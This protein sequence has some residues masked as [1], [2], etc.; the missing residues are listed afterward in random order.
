MIVMHP[1]E[2]LRLVTP[3][4]DLTEDAVC[5][6]IRIPAFRIEVQLRRKIVKDRPESLIGVSLVEAHRHIAGEVD[7]KTAVGFRPPCKNRLATLAI[8]FLH[9]SVPPDPLSA[10]FSKQGA[11]CAG[12]T[13]RAAGCLPASFSFL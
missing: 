1:N 5:F 7:R 3:D 4:N 9:G 2:V 13:S 10:S 12:E 6:D 11:H 8:V